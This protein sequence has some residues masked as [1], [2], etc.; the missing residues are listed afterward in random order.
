VRRGRAAAEGMGVELGP[1]DVLPELTITADGAFMHPFAP[2][3][4]NGRTDIDL[5]VSR[6]VRPLERA[7]SRF[8]AIAAGLPGGG[9]VV[10]N[11]R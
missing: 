9:D 5:L 2:T 3:V 4:R 8:L 6:Q 11:I 7:M 10:R 1:T